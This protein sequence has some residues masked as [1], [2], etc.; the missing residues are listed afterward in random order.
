MLFIK[1][2]ANMTTNTQI[3]KANGKVSIQ[4]GF[5]G[6]TYDFTGKHAVAD[7]CST[8]RGWVKSGLITKDEGKALVATAKA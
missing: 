3:I 6:K 8:L 1:E 2:A 7:V 4:C 5:N